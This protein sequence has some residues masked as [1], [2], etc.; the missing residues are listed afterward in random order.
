MPAA[1]LVR[2][3]ECREY[4]PSRHYPVVGAVSRGVR[5]AVC[6]G[7]GPAPL[8]KYAA[9]GWASVEGGTR[10]W[11]ANALDK[12]ITGLS[13][14][15]IA[16]ED[17]LGIACFQTIEG[18]PDDPAWENFLRSALAGVAGSGVLRHG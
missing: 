9:H 16:V 3:E 17:A 4:K 13:G 7:C 6:G 10:G 2:C 11:V 18:A 12:R 5:S 15:V 1:K 14:A 8:E